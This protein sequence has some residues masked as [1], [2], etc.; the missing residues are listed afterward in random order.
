MLGCIFA[1]WRY[2]FM[3]RHISVKNDIVSLALVP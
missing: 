1:E 2:K 3:Y